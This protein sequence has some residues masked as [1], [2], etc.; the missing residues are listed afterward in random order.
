MK[1][2]FNRESNSFSKSTTT[3]KSFFKAPNKG[4][5]RVGPKANGSL[6]YNS[7]KY[8]KCRKLVE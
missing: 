2:S 1:S 8:F 4:S 5:I 3:I 7:K 6:S